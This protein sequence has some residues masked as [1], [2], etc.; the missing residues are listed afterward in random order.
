MPALLSTNQNHRAMLMNLDKSQL[1]HK[2][3][4]QANLNYSRYKIS[5]SQKDLLSK[6]EAHE[7][8]IS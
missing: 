5:A 2:F 1:K 8:E 6:A 4:T 3:V 7:A